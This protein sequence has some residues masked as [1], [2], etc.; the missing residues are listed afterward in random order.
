MEFPALAGHKKSCD[1]NRRS[2]KCGKDQG[3]K[4][5]LRSIRVSSPGVYHRFLYKLGF[6]RGCERHQKIVNTTTGEAYFLSAFIFFD[7]RLAGRCFI[8]QQ[9]VN[10]QAGSHLLEKNQQQEEGYTTLYN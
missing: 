5:S 4:I 6:I 8:M 2:A 9:V 10:K 3:S 7:R 1:E